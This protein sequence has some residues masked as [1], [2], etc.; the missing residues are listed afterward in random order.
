M[1][2]QDRVKRTMFYHDLG[3]DEKI[4]HVPDKDS[5]VANPFF[6]QLLFSNSIFYFYCTGF[7]C[8]LELQ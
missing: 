1:I 3:K 4:N 6:W 2:M 5:I 8:I 7:Y